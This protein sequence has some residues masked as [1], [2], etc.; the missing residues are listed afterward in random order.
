MRAVPSAGPRPL[1]PN[2][3]Y[4]F[5]ISDPPPPPPPRPPG[6][7]ITGA[8]R[9]RPRPLPGHWS[10]CQERGGKYLYDPMVLL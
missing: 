6:S 3:S 5:L 4:L 9:Y 7:V 2:T 8:I 1:P 10:H